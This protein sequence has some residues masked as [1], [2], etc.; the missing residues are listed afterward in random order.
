MLE[1][2]REYARQALD[3]ATECELNERHADYFVALGEEAEPHLR[4]DPKDWLDLLE[5]E[6]DNFRGALDYLETADPSRQLRLAAKI[7]RFWIVRGPF[8]EGRRRIERA[9]ALAPPS[10]GVDV[11]VEA[12]QRAAELARLEGAH[13]LS[14]NL[15]RE[16]LELARGISDWHGIGA[17]LHSLANLAIAEGDLD[18]ASALLDESLEPLRL[19]GD[20]RALAITMSTRGYLALSRTDY[21]A[22]AA[23]CQESLT[24][25]TEIENDECMIL[26]LLNLG[27]ATLGLERLDDASTAFVRSLRLATS[28]GWKDWASYAQEGIAAVAAARGRTD[29]AL[30]VLA[31]A[32]AMR[33]EIG[34][35]LDPVEQEVHDKTLDL[36]RKCFSQEAIDA[37]FEEARQLT[38]EEAWGRALESLA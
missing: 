4:V 18:A 29:Q 21:K 20:K 14:G 34:T 1:T 16:S 6:L 15:T 23:H 38:E 24:L 10:E 7:G 30:R 11:R 17:A 5:A 37:A 19:T 27:F 36:I 31:S 28:L 33:E 26:A 32:I 3:A 8:V 25:A 35:Q 9:L 13:T 12:L 2:I 22:A